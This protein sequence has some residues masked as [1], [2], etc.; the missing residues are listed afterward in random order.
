[1]RTYYKHTYIEDI[2]YRTQSH[3]TQLQARYSYIGSWKQS[4]RYSDSSN[5]MKSLVEITRAEVPFLPLAK[6]HNT[7]KTL[8]YVLLT[9]ILTVVVVVAANPIN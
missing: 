9:L 7:F 8:F 6:I 2:Y 4:L 1:M 3:T 5:H